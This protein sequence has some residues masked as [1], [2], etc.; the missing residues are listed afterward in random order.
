M[1]MFE[2]NE[3]NETGVRLAFWGWIGVFVGVPLMAFAAGCWQMFCGDGVG[4]VLWHG[5]PFLIG[6]SMG[7]LVLASSQGLLLLPRAMERVRGWCVTALCVIAVVQISLPNLATCIT[8]AQYTDAPCMANGLPPVNVS[9][10]LF[11]SFSPPVFMGLYVVLR[12]VFAGFICVLALRIVAWWVPLLPVMVRNLRRT[13]SPGWDKLSVGLLVLMALLAF[14][15]EPI[16]SFVVLDP[17]RS[18]AKGIAE[19]DDLV[20][21]HDTIRVGYRVCPQDNDDPVIQNP[22]EALL[23]LYGKYGACTKPGC[24]HIS[25]SELSRLSPTD[26]EFLSRILTAWNRQKALSL[27]KLGN[28]SS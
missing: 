21:E 24:E 20:R 23:A 14:F 9:P 19:I 27:L 15:I 28:G 12:M 18:E 7:Y 5:V 4:P 3:N 6:F 1:S 10:V 13:L 11:L 25:T 17:L 16:I 26:R 22:R 2:L 8:V